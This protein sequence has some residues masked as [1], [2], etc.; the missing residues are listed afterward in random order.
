MASGAV[1]GVVIGVLLLVVIIVIFTM[2]ASSA[3]AAPS[4]QG[5]QASP[6]AAANASPNSAVVTVKDTPAGPVARTYYYY[7]GMDSPGNDIEN[8]GLNDNVA[9]L[10]SRCD[11]LPSCKGFN[12]NA[13][14]KH[15]ILPQ[16][17]WVKWTDDPNKGSYF[18]DKY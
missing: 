16:N 10:K 8:S 12:T 18:V 5:P 6:V 11:A 14:M 1:I 13:W 9:A 15:T 4:P 3:P 7:P 17:K 2:S